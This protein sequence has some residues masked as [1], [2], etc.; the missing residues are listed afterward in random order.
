[1][2]GQLIKRGENK[3]L[4]KLFMGRDPQTGKKRFHTKM[5]HGPKKDAQ[6]YLTALAREKYLGTLVE[7]VKLTFGEF[8][9]RW[10][11]AAARPRL[12]ERTL[13]DY[14]YKIDL[15][16]LP[17]LGGVKLSELSP[18]HIQLL[19]SKMQE[20]GL[21]AWS[22]RY[23][24]LIISSSLKYAV[25][26]RMLPNNPA[27]LVELPR[28]ERKEM[29]AFSREDA[30]RFLKAAAEDRHET[31]FALALTTGMRPEE[32]LGLQWKDVDLVKGTVTVQRTLVQRMGGGWYFGEPKTARSRRT[33]PLPSS[34]L[35]SLAEHRRRQLEARM[36]AGES[37]HNHDLV[38]ATADGGPLHIRNLTNRHFK[39]I[40]ERAKLAKT[41]RLYDLRHSCATLLLLANEHP[42]VVSERLGHASI[43]LTLDTYSHVLPSMQQ[44]ATEKLESLLWGT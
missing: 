2:A 39:P 17:S 34:V 8:L 14:Q 28:R 9:S 27:A 1:M 42:K 15:Y 16:I 11:E 21:R 12:R 13:D 22:V 43:N 19:Y 36:S 38:F 33:I 32:Y 40:L 20:R 5:V 23:V 6:K 26:Q 4:V 24:H 10:V 35:K 18:L 37:Y 29:R 30:A 25:R 31:L 44:A 3:W 41:F 7:P